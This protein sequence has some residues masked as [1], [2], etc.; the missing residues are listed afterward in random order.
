MRKEN[1]K[2]KTYEQRNPDSQ[3]QELLKMILAG[4]ETGDSEYV[5]HPDQT[6][7]TYT[8]KDLPPLVYKFENGFPVITDRKISFWGAPISELV[9]FISGVRHAQELTLRGCKWWER[10]ATPD[11]CAIFG[12]EPGDLGHGSYGAAYHD[13]PM[14]DGGKFNQFEHVIKQM[15]EKPSI[16][17]HVV[18][19][20]IPYYT[21]QNSELVRKVVVAPCHGNFLQF[22]ITDRGLTLNHVQRSADMPIGA[23]ANI[24][25]YAALVYMMA[26]ILG[27]EPYQYIHYFPD[28]QI[29]ENQ[30]DAVREIVSREPRRLP[31]FQIIDK[32]ITRLE[33]FLPE[34]FALSDYHPHPPVSGIP[35]TE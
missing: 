31:T 29:Y 27:V 16:R 9:S 1:N 6:Q 20:W 35:V 21:L 4:I 33:E 18:T 25:Q 32:S 34:H 23:P 14:P 2:V 11:K 24:I 13:F 12:L 26:Q 28:A 8:R 19:S 15:K 10:W 22:T 7:G 17:T 5:K 3:Y 30:I